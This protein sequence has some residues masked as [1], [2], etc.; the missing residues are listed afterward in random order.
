MSTLFQ[1][2]LYSYFALSTKTKYLTSELSIICNE[3]TADVYES[4][5]PLSIA[6]KMP[7]TSN[8]FSNTE[9]TCSPTGQEISYRLCTDQNA[10][11]D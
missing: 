2:F 11:S 7:L 3:T 9:P 6:L 1:L 4:G 10:I 8:M 5:W